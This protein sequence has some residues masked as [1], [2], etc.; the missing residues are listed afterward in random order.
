MV[1]LAPIESVA[2][3]TVRHVEPSADTEPVTV[4]PERTSL[5]QAGRACTSPAIQF[6]A[7]PVEG[8]VSNSILVFGLASIITCAALAAVDSRIITPAFAY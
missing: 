5:S 2:E 7:A 1:A 8:R 6:V 4:D 3:P